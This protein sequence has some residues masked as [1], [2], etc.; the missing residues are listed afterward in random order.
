MLTVQHAH[1]LLYTAC[2]ITHSVLV[3]NLQ[4]EF[5]IINLATILRSKIFDLNQVCR[6]VG[7]W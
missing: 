4:C 5:D 1:T 6:V 3:M 7:E 2:L